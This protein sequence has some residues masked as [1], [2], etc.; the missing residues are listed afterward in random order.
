[1]LEIKDGIKLDRTLFGYF[2][3]HFLVN[4]VIAEHIFFL[5]CF[6][7]R[8]MFRFLIRKKVQG[9]NEVTRNLSISVAEKSNGY[10]MIRQDLARKDRVDIESIN[11]VYELIFD[12]NIPIP[13]FYG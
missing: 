13:C 10:E 8:D 11:I 7:Q 9:K 12:E 5:T 3:R 6:E 4:Q 2:D 1:M